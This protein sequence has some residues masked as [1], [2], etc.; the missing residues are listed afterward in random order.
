MYF[1]VLT[2]H[3]HDDSVTEI[4]RMDAPNSKMHSMPLRCQAEVRSANTEHI[5]KHLKTMTHTLECHGGYASLT[6]LQAT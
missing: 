6:T 3:S 1:H 2:A 5:W 4:S